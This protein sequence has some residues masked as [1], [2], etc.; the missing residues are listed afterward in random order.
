[1]KKHKNDLNDAWLVR[2]KSSC[3]KL[4]LVD[5]GNI[6]TSEKILMKE[7]VDVT[8]RELYEEKE[9]TKEIFFISR[10]D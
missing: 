3:E 5:G 1:M 4:I 6:C 7:I 2:F 9:K 8:W 10:A